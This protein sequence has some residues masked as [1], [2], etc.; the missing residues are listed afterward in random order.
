[1][2]KRL[3]LEAMGTAWFGLQMAQR[4]TYTLLQSREEVMFACLK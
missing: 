4:I 2:G 3:A 1:M